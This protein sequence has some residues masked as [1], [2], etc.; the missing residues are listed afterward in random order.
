M[1]MRKKQTKMHK[2]PHLQ[3]F[4]QRKKDWQQALFSL[5]AIMISFNL[6]AQTPIYVGTGTTN[7]NGSSTTA[8]AVN[9]S[10]YGIN[11]GSGSMSKK[12]QI[13][14]TKTQIDAALTAASLSTGSYFI[15]NLTFDV[16]TAVGTGNPNMLSYTV[17]M[18]N[19]AQASFTSTSNPYTGSFT[20]VYSANTTYSG[21]TG[22]TTPLALP[23]PFQ[24]DGTNNLIVEVCY[25]VTGVSLIGNYGGCRRTT[26]TNN[27]IIYA[28]AAN[29]NGCSLSS[30]NQVI[31]AICNVK[32]GVTSATPCSGTPNVSTAGSDVVCSGVSTNI[33]LTGLAPAANYS[34]LWKQS[35]NIGGPY[36]PAS[37]TNTN[38]TYDTPNTLPFNPTYYIC[39]VTCNNSSM[40]TPSLPGTVSLN[41]FMNC[42]CTGTYAS[43]TQTNRGIAGVTLNG[44]PAI[45]NTGTS[46]TTTYALYTGAPPQANAGL[47]IG[48]AYSLGV[49]VGSQTGTGS[50]NQRIMAWIDYNQ[51]GVFEA[52]EA[53][54]AS[55][56]QVTAA[57]GTGTINFTVPPTALPGTTRMRVRHR[58]GNNT[59]GTGDACTHLTGAVNTGGAGEIEDYN[60]LLIASCTPPSISAS[61]SST[62]IL[63]TTSATLQWTNGNGNA[64]RIVVLRQGAAV[65]SG[66]LSGNTYTANAA[67]GSGDLLGTSNYVVYNNTGNSVNITNLLPSTTYHYAIYEYNSTGICYELTAHTGSFTTADCAPTANATSLYYTDITNVSMTAN[68]TRGNGT[69]VL[70]V[71]RLTATTRVAPTYNVT[72][73]PNTVFGT[74][75][76]LET[77][78]TGN[79]VVYNGTGTNVNITGLS[80]F[81]NYTVDVYEYN[82]SPNCYWF[83]TPL[84]LARTTLDGTTS[85]GCG[86]SVSRTTGAG[87]YTAITPAV[88]LNNT[89]VTTGYY[90]GGAI[91]TPGSGI[92]IGF[93]FVYNGVTYT[94]FGLGVKGYIWFGS[95][96]PS[97]T[98]THVISNPSAN[99]GGSGTIDGLISAVGTNIYTSAGYHTGRS[100]GYTLS[101]VA[102]NRV[103][104]I[105]WKGYSLSSSNGS[106]D[107]YEDILGP[108]YSDGNRLDFQIILNENGGA[109]SNKIGIAYQDMNPFCVDGQSGVEAQIG[110]RGANNTDFT[111]RSGNA[112]NNWALNAGTVNTASCTMGTANYINGNV[113]LTFTQA[114]LTPPVINVGSLNCPAG[115]VTLTAPLS[116]Y[117]QWFLNGSIIPGPGSSSL[118]YTTS[119]SG[120]YTVVTKNGTCYKQ[121]NPT[122]VTVNSCGPIAYAVTGG[123]NCY[124]TTVGVANSETGVTYEL[125][126]DGNPTGQTQSGSTGNPISFGPQTVPGLYTVV[127]TDAQPVSTGM[128]GNARVYYSPVPAITGGPIGCT[129]GGLVLNSSGSTAGTGTIS[130]RQWQLNTVDI[131]LATN[132]FYVANTSGDYTVVITNSVGCTAVSSISTITMYDPP[133]ASGSGPLSTCE[134]GPLTVSGATATNGTINW[135]LLVGNG[136]LSNTGTISPTYTPVAADAGTNVSLLLTVSNPGCTNAT[137]T[138]TIQVRPRPSINPASVSICTLTPSAAINIVSPQPSTDYKWSPANDLYLDAA[139]SIPYTLGTPATTVYTAPFGNITY[140]VTATNTIDNCETG[141]NSVSVTVCPALTNNICDADLQPPVSVTTTPLF[142]PYSLTGATLSGGVSC[143]TIS[144]DV[145]YRTIVPANGELHVVT[146]S[147][148]N[149]IPSL[150]VQSTVVT[151]FTGPNCSS[152]SSVACNSN[153]AAGDFSYTHVNNLTPGSTAYIRLASTLANNPPAAQFVKM[154]VTSGLIW[155]AASDD[156]INNPANWHGGDATALTKPDA[157]ISV[158]VPTTVSTKPKLYANTTIRGALFVAQPPYFNSQGLDL[159]G[160]KLNVKEN[161]NAGPVANAT[162]KL[163]CN[164]EVEFNGTSATPQAINAKAT[165]GNLII[166]NTVAGVDLNN[167]VVVSCI[168]TA[169]GGNLN[170]NGNLILRS[171]STTTALVKP[172]SGNINGNVSVERKVGS[173]TGYHYLSSPVSGAY[174]NDPVTGWRD[175]FTILAAYDNMVFIPGTNYLV[176]PTVWEYDETDV[177]PVPE[178][179][180]ISATAS[181]DPITPLKGFACVVPGNTT[182]DVFGPLNNGSIPGG[183]NIT[184]TAG[185]GIGEGINA[186]GNPYASPISWS[187]FRSLPGNSILIDEYRVFMSSGGYVGTYGTY[188]GGVGNPPIV[189]NSIASSQGIMVTATATGTINANNSI[190]LTS[191]ADLSTNYF[192][193]YNTVPDLIRLEV[194]GNGYNDITTIYFSSL[195][196]DNYSLTDDAKLLPAR[197]SGV[198]NIYSYIEQTPLSIN[199]M[200]S[201]NSDKVVPLGLRIQSAGTYTIKATDMTDLA[202][203]VMVYLEDLHAGIITNLRS[204]PSYTATL[205]GGNINNRFILHFHPAVELN[206]FNESCQGN[207]G[208]LVINYPTSNTVN[209]AIKDQNGVLISNHNNVNGT[210]TIDHLSMGNYMAE[211]TFGVSPNT[212]TAVDYF[213]IGGGNAIPTNIVASTN[214]VDMAANTDVVFTATAQ[215]ASAY[216]WNFGD[217]NII[218][219]GPANVM[220]SFTQAGTYTVTVEVSNGL[221][222]STAA[223]TVVVNNTTGIT[224]MNNNALSISGIGNK[225]NI[226]FGSKFDGNANIELID[227]SGK[228]VASYSQVLMKGKKVFELTNI[229]AGQYLVKISNNKQLFT[230]KV[231]LSRQ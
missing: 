189:G 101:G 27:Q 113:L 192:S 117:Y 157:S 95:G 118:T 25:S 123:N 65:N 197:L 62:P 18:A 58:F 143:A 200:G 71:A 229:A 4:M 134:N 125:Y 23:T 64:G 78:G 57:N 10:P 82:A 181:D 83:N 210:L 105:Q 127:G 128:T 79:F 6:S 217:G 53:L 76:G 1:M 186:I 177:N 89:G 37:G 187:A 124:S 41:N 72:Y 114:D 69:H 175:D 216:N 100:I 52:S 36:T 149:P 178:Y 188:S 142:K 140:S 133:T 110:L 51:N 103:L 28:G 47:T 196:Q 43:S 161:W 49:T 12:L 193:G 90:Q 228:V 135:T 14:Y 130:S 207:D 104:K 199:K 85:G 17:S 60:V 50:S 2:N 151:I 155:T 209:I 75:T 126:L 74:G 211:M 141:A 139:L 63:N 223:T 107:F 55:N 11:V 33:G 137:Y 39:E 224:V 176:L 214:S 167:S 162:V 86:A 164:G 180:W 73:T 156:D 81:T 42:Y 208:K 106:C 147:G 40:M 198:P 13:I 99:L 3:A 84:S 129:A 138:Q 170:S 91:N 88:V 173:T 185:T 116:S 146:T 30:Y 150:N 204:N 32:F 152:L 8:A 168:L 108:G 205:A 31:P 96:V 122:P 191:P 163:D 38:S 93:D 98:A 160:F 21:G 159:N 16:S 169:Q 174:V 115:T 70:V 45:S 148:S 231:Y 61:A 119:V 111:N 29:T 5:W 183:Y 225:L 215:G 54:S 218:N 144:R 34:Y 92:P 77:T 68:W 109:N 87:Q 24:W 26:T 9:A 222:T 221:C 179:G 59:L 212:Y 195:G 15:H 46:A 97:P 194:E 213:T 220:H 56:I 112:N 44:V 80:N 20:T 227:M 153:G 132:T 165:F 184:Q 219:N 226:D 102:P 66:P 166:N 35:A 131:P 230:E 94:T 171:T 206:A 190:R 203:S 22:F 67:F 48:N 145:W 7:I 202:P 158:I 172:V 120:T 121:S 136:S 154:A 19:A 182:V 201:L